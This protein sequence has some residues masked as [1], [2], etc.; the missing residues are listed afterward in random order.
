MI[1]RSCL[2][3]FAQDYSSLLRLGSF[4][5]H[6]SVGPTYQLQ[7]SSSGILN[8]IQNRHYELDCLILSMLSPG[9]AHEFDSYTFYSSLQVSDLPICSEVVVA[10]GG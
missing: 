6:G 8:A 7:G 2:V 5:Q 10:F 3:I 1:Q 9:I 4:L